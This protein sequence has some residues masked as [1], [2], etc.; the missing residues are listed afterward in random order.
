MKKRLLSLFLAAGLIV[1]AFATPIPATAE[2]A[3]QN[4]TWE[5]TLGNG[6]T[7]GDKGDGPTV[8][9]VFDI[10]WYE[11]DLE[12][13]TIPGYFAVRDNTEFTLRFNKTAEDDNS[14]IQIC[15]APYVYYGDDQYDGRYMWEESPRVMVLTPD[16]EFD[17][18][19]NAVESKLIRAGESVTF[20]LPTIYAYLHIGSE[21]NVKTEMPEVI[22]HLEFRKFYPDTAH[23]VPGM[24]GPVTE[25][26]YLSKYAD[27]KVDNAAVDKYLSE[28][29]T[30]SFTDVPAGEWYAAPVD[31]AVSKDITNGTGNGEFSPGKQCT[32]AQILTF[33]YRAA[34][35]QGKAEAADMD[36]A[37]T[38]AREK[39]MIDGS[40]NGSEPCTRADA[41]NYIWQ[42]LGKEDAPASSFTDV[43]PNAS[44]AKAVDWAVANG[45]TNGT[46]TAQ[47]EFSPNTVCTRGHIVT[48]LH[49][50]Y[51]PEVRLK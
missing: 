9:K 7:A 28:S 33:L 21:W 20:K 50:A 23:E 48:F 42:A 6:K 1:P 14:F 17:Y 18:N 30:P 44:Y 31:W 45:V 25:Y 46:N 4:V 26:S 11:D 13:G 43:D 2:E 38:W 37:V 35:G 19:I 51:V 12:E 49:R 47:T 16:G 5:Y 8:E 32:H 34:R 24:H 27:F 41:V 39:G 36:K 3:F 22:Y 29:S 10:A 40:F 15:I